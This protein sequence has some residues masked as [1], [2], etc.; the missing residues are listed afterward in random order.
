VGVVLPEVGANVLVQDGEEWR[1]VRGVLDELR[2]DGRDEGVGLALK[3]TVFDCQTVEKKNKNES[4]V[5][6]VRQA[7]AGDE[8]HRC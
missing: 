6:E 8:T 1:R 2:D 5:A 4:S 7:R 3:S